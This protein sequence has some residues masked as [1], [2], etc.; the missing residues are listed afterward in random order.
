MFKYKYFE[1]DC[2]SELHTI[3]FSIDEEDNEIY[4]SIQLH[5]PNNFFKRIWLGVKYILGFESKCGHWDCT[6]LKNED[7]PKLIELLNRHKK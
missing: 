3:R 2:S 4:L 7:I 1:C 5:Q 6:I